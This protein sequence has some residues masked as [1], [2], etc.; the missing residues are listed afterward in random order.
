MTENNEP[1]N[2][3]GNNAPQDD[4]R[5]CRHRGNR[6]HSGASR[7]L[8]GILAAVGIVSLANIAFG[9]SSCDQERSPTERATKVAIHMLDD[10][11][12][13][14]EQRGQVK[15]IIEAHSA[16]LNALRE[17]GRKLHQETRRLLSAPTIDRNAIENLR[18]QQVASMDKRSREMTAM[19]ADIAEVLTPEQRQQLADKMKDRFE[20]HHGHHWD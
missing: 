1:Q 18:Q 16:T 7:L 19:L 17:S 4:I 13:S 9:A 15:S 6:R 2:E 12:A 3:N 5:R 20:R 8:I 14:D 11:D 10:V